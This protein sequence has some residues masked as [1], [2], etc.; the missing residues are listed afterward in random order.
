[1]EQKN[2]KNITIGIL[3]VLVVVLLAWF[4]FDKKEAVAPEETSQATSE[5]TESS[6]VEN[7]STKPTTTNTAPRPI[8]NTVTGG[9]T[10]A[11]TVT[12]TEAGFSPS[13]IVIKKGETIRFINKASTTRMWVASGPHPSH[14]A[15][16]GFD[17]GTSVGYNGTYDFT[18]TTTGKF[19]FHN[20]VDTRRDGTIVVNYE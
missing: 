5:K 19:P 12:Y 10:I 9:K 20:H 13:I 2:K 15:Y 4:G 14:S 3:I 1:M 8:T 6:K 17:H 16:P 18:F 11:A 7:G